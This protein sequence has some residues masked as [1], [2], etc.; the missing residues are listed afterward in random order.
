MLDLCR[1]LYPIFRS[2][3]G[4]GTLKTLGILDREIGRD[5][6]VYEVASGQRVLDWTV[7]KEWNVRRAYIETLD[8]KKIVD[9]A[10]SNLHLL[11]YSV[12][13]NGVLPFAE[14]K[15]HIHTLPQQP[16]L[17]PYRTGY[18]SGTW[19]FCMAHNRLLE[20]KEERY[21]VV[22]DS[23]LKDGYL[24]Y[25]ELF[26]PAT[27]P[28]YTRCPEMLFSIHVCHPS[29]ANDN[30]SGMTVAVELVKWLK[31]RK[32]RAVNYRFLFIPGTIG[33]ICWLDENGE[34]AKRNVQYGLVLS[35]VGDGGPITYKR[36]R[37]GDALIDLYVEHV[38]KTSDQPHQVRDFI[39]YGYDERQY[40]SPG[41]NLPVGCFMR[42]PN[43]EFPEYHTSA[44]NLDFIQEAALQ[45][46][47]D[48]LKQ[49]VE[50]VEWGDLKYYNKNP[51]GEPQLGK[52]GLYK[53]VGGEGARSALGSEQRTTSGYDQMTLLW[54]LNL[55][56]DGRTLYDIAARA[57][58]PFEAVLNAAQAL[59]NADL[60]EGPPTIRDR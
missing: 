23:E 7:P 22:I 51:F 20:M 37:R 47:L 8:G 52:R 35:C 32:S 53:L 29:L 25:G 34:D 14:L 39:P 33:S 13:L 44:D 27:A 57:K 59:Y 5:M 43:G 6:T 18:Y 55:A 11:H 3:T 30:L 58:L 38:L 50:L 2:I 17:V 46:S 24:A 10:D 48:K 21:R 40:C 36:S 42:T 60:L 45:D 15:Q 28:W 9:I 31:A 16:D 49:V 1:E 54:V 26:I 19:G 41:F 12:P 56:Y 4:A